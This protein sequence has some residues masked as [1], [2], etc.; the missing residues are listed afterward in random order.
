[1]PRF[2]EA[3]PGTAFLASIVWYLASTEVFPLTNIFAVAALLVF[4]VGWI[5]LN[6]QG[7]A[8][9]YLYGRYEN[10]PVMKH[11]RKNIKLR[12]MDG[13]KSYYIDLSKVLPP[14]YEKRTITCCRQEYEKLFDPFKKLRYFPWSYRR[15]QEKNKEEPY[16][17]ENVENVTY[18][19]EKL[20]SSYMREII[21]Y[22]HISTSSG[23]GFLFGLLV[24]GELF[25]IL[26]WKSHLLGY[27]LLV[28]T[29]GV[30]IIFSGFQ[31]HFRRKE[32]IANEFLFIK[33]VV[34]YTNTPPSTTLNEWKNTE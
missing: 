17:V 3:V 32:A 11:I 20:W 26:S 19:S 18:F 34:P 16:Y 5:L 1:M 4:P 8:L 27:A 13:G 25:I 7:F 22:W 28:F 29:L 23:I 14:S 2:I 21:R 33:L 30:L 9:T 6:I 12:K 10:E 31:S 24:T 15:K